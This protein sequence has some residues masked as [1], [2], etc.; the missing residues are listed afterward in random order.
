MAFAHISLLH[1]IVWTTQFK[2]FF[3]SQVSYGIVL[4][5]A[6]IKLFSIPVIDEEDKNSKNT[7]K[8][9]DKLDS[10]DLRTSFHQKISLRSSVVVQWKRIR[11][12]TMRSWV[13]SLASLSG[14]RIRCCRKLWWRS[15]TQL[16]SG[17]TVAVV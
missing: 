7:N 6:L 13:Q 2:W 11:R 10:L 9:K 12:G 15:Q 8:R 5:V 17:V 4:S 16:G 3:T 1:F 14:L